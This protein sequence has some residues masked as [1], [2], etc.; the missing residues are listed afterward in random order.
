MGMRRPLIIGLLGLVALVLALALDRRLEIGDRLESWTQSA[1]VRPQPATEGMTPS[2]IPAGELQKSQPAIPL[3]LP[4][5]AQPSGVSPQPP[6][7]SAVPTF[8]VVRVNPQGDAVIAGRAP[9]NAEVTVRDGD[10]TLGTATA[11]QRGEWVLLPAE[12][13]SPGVRELGL[14]AKV[15]DQPTVSSDRIV[16]LSIEERSRVAVDEAASAAKPLA[17][18]IDRNV[19]GPSTLL[20]VPSAPSAPSGEERGGGLTLDVIDYSAKGHVLLAGRGQAGSRAMAYLDNVASASG[21]IDERGQ[22]RAE[23]GATVPPGNYR[24]RI[25]QIAPSGRVTARLEV[26]FS[27]ADAATLVLGPSQIVVQPGNSLWRI[28]RRSYGQG[29]NFTLIYQANLDQIRDPDLIYPGQILTM[30]KPN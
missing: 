29:T 7:P 23:F 26:P 27:R 1:G 21:D 15:G 30:P 8:D 10:R 3:I 25:D 20:Q 28:A 22:W 13:L 18:L 2:P 16:V 9:P 24:L 5:A 6:R 14:S 19:G 11:D 17:V 4:D 12:P